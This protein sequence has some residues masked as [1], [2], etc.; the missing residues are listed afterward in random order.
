[1][2]E[3]DISVFLDG[4]LKGITSSEYGGLII[5]NIVSGPHLIKVVKEGYLPQEETINI[6]SGEVFT[7]HVNKDFIP[8]IRITEKGNQ[9]NQAISIKKGNLKIQSLPIEISISIPSLHIE[10]KK[11][12]DEWFANDIPEGEYKVTFKWSSKTVE[13]VIR[14]ENDMVSY[15]F[16]NMID[17]KVENKSIKSIYENT[18][19]QSF[20]NQINTEP[21]DLSTA[22]SEPTPSKRY[23]IKDGGVHNS[24]GRQDFGAVLLTVLLAIGIMAGAGLVIS[25]F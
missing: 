21:V 18:N 5:Q 19:R 11:S 25:L 3:P 14:I 9:E 20:S 16:V 24:D 8:S 2:S 13:D 12:K 1:V 22:I 15:V 17:G 6:K 7:Y 4:Q 10:T 23:I